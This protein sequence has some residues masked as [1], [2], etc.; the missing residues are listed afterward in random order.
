MAAEKIKLPIITDPDELRQAVAELPN[1]PDRPIVAKLPTLE[2]YVDAVYGD[3]TASLMAQS[4]LRPHRGIGAHWDIHSPY[5]DT[6]RPFVA[7]YTRRGFA[8]LRATQLRERLH[9]DYIERYPKPTVEARAARRAYSKLALKT[10]EVIY[11]ADITPGTG[12]I[13]PQVLGASPLVHNI[14]PEP[15]YPSWANDNGEFVKL[16]TPSEANDAHTAHQ[17]EGYRSY[18]D[19]LAD[20]EARRQASERQRAQE[21]EE[22]QRRSKLEEE[23]RAQRVLDHYRGGRGRIMGRPRP[24]W[25]HLLD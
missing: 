21:D 18:D 20:E 17:R 23:A 12:L 2:A 15:I 9:M 4:I 3:D 16:V 1:N 19:F 8:A 10:A 7:T 14:L 11:K 24:G 5:V 6:E 22:R 13:V 25:P